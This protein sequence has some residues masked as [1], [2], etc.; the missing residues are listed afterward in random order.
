[1][2]NYNNSMGLAITKAPPIEEAFNR[3]QRD[4][5]ITAVIAENDLYRYCG[6]EQANTFFERCKNVIVLDSLHNQTTE[7]ASVVIPAATFAEADGTVVNYEGRAQRFYQ[8]FVPAHHHVKESWKWLLTMRSLQSETTNG[9]DHAPGKII[10]ELENTLP[11][12][13]G[14]SKASLPHDLRV[15]GQLIPREPHRYS[16]RTA[17]VANLHVSEPKP[18][19]D[20]DSPLSFT[21]EGYKGIP[22]GSAIPFFWAPGW[23]SV[24]SVN[25]YQEE[26]GGRLKD[27]NPGVLLFKEKSVSTPSF[28]TDKPDSFRARP[29]KWL[30]LPQQNIYGTGELSSYTPAM[31]QLSP[32]P[33]IAMSG[34]DLKQM[35]ILEGAEVEIVMGN[36]SYKLPVKLNHDLADGMALVFAGENGIG[37]L[38]WGNW[39]KLNVKLR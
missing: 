11:Q 22:P 23:N 32:K 15:N 7:K 6:T 31:Q 29:G 33:Y 12:F 20:E 8:V 37:G 18:L 19:S 34:N 38:G 1:M 14:I 2:V 13:A 26:I 24:Q 21:M 9:Q 5:N 30:L 36:N 16:G 3:V 39:G 27:A 10:V 35:G 4:E 25:K 28:F 17:M